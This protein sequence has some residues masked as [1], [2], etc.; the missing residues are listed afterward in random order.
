MK[1]IVFISFLFSFLLAEAHDYY[2]SFAE[3]QYNYDAKRFEVSVRATGHDVEEF[4]KDREYEIP[5]LEKSIGNPV[6][7]N[8]LESYVTKYFKVLVDGKPL[9]F[10]LVGLEVNLKDEVIFYLKSNKLEKP[11]AIEI[12]YDLLMDYFPDQQNKLTLFTDN[13]KDY[14]GFLPHR[15]KRIYEYD[16]N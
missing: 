12:V 13:G 9:E 10:T 7:E 15:R 11:K 5:S 16:K 1:I 4:L 8:I 6:A 2:F 3:M 14:L